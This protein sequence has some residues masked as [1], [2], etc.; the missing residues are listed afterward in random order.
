[1]NQFLSIEVVRAEVQLLELAHELVMLSTADD[2][3][4]VND[5]RITLTYVGRGSE[6][7]MLCLDE[8]YSDSTRIQYARENMA[9]LEKIKSDLVSWAA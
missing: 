4:E 5:N 7:I 2:V 3:V 6:S 1:M 8:K 9:R